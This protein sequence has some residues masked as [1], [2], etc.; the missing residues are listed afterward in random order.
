MG[1]EQAGSTLALDGTAFAQPDIRLMAMRTMRLTAILLP[2]VLLL[3]RGDAF[4]QTADER[5]GTLAAAA[6]RGYANF[7]IFDDVTIDVSQGTITLQGKVT[8]PVKRD[9]IGR[10]VGKID[11]TR[12]VVNEIGVLPVS[13][14]DDDLRAR[15]ARAIYNHPSFWHYAQMA[16]PPIHIIVEHARITLTGRVATETERMLAYSLAQ[17]GGSLGVTNALKLDSRSPEGPRQ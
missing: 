15:V 5:L 12:T 11:G 13:R 9:E 4:G 14:L 7:T 16:S 6:V 3:G 1:R 10:R 2:L 17:V 8:S